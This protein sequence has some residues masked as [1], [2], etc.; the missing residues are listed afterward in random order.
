MDRDYWNDQLSDDLDEEHQERGDDGDGNDV[1]EQHTSRPAD[2]PQLLATRGLKQRLNRDNLAENIEAIFEHMHDVGLDL[3]LFLDAVCWGDVD[4]RQNASICWQRTALMVSDELPGILK[5]CHKPPRS[6]GKGTRT[7]GGNC[8]FE[9]FAIQCVEKAINYEMN[10]IAPLM[11]SPPSDINTESLTDIKFDKLISELKAPTGCPTLWRL[12]RAANYSKRQ[13]KRN[14]SKN[15]DLVSTYCYT[16]S[17]ASYCR[18]HHRCRIPKLLSLYLKVCGAS[19]RSL[20]VLHTLGLTMSHR[21]IYDGMETL[22]KTS[23]DTLRKDIKTTPWL[24]SHDNLNIPFQKYE[25]RLDNQSHFD[26]G[27]AATV[28]LAKGPNVPR[29]NVDKLRECRATGSK[30]PFNLYDLFEA[31]SKAGKDFR[32]RDIRRVLRFLTTA[33]EFS[34]ETYSNKKSF[35]F[36]PAPPV[37][38]LPSGK[39][40]KTEQYMLATVHIEEAS[41][42]GNSQ[43]LGEWFRQLGLGSEAEQKKTGT[44]RVIPWIG[45]QLTISR[46]RGLFNYRSEDFNS[47]DRMDSFVL[48]FGWLHTMM[49]FETSLHDQYL[50]TASGHGLRQAFEILQRKGLVTTSTKGPF[51]HHL[52]EAIVHVGE[53]HFRSCWLAEGGVKK[54][55]DLRSKSPEELRRIAVRIIQFHASTQALVDHDNIEPSDQDEVNRQVTMWNRDVLRFFD[56]SEAI[57]TGDVGIMEQHIP[58]LI[59]RFAGGNNSKYLIELFEL[60]QALRKEWPENV[61]NFVLSHCWL[62]NSTGRRDGFCPVDMAQEHNVR[63]IKYTF[64]SLGPYATWEYINKISPAIPTFRAVKDHIEDELG[65]CARGKSH[66][67]PAKENDVSKLAKIYSTQ[68]LHR[69]TP[70]RKI[71]N[72]LD[73]S[74]D[75]VQRGIEQ[76]QTT[77]VMDRWW[78]NRTY[79]READEI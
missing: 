39:L 45:D 25:Q 63:D 30:E 43:L 19:A 62:V 71:K 20:D 16:I 57:R 79:G 21:W 26:S 6:N 18:S 9:A 2:C 38:Q 65:A 12:L 29:L 72:R 10:A 68:D 4:C 3:P 56:M 50:G 11:K 73:K 54:L 64:A 48:V 1:S 7:K 33:P 74:Q 69:P 51:H 35:I 37:N 52:E 42:E 34:F 53:A 40:H 47:F 36:A 8:S 24:I 41:Y 66:T 49:T 46:L 5:R 23:M 70:K 27:T 17:M 32:E 28:F 31:D 15:P 67:L 55:S 60:F 75:F 76:L 13:E 77:S 61:K 58:H 22:A 59:F 14:T 78:E 44:E